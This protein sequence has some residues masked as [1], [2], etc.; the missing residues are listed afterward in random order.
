MDESIKKA[1]K[2]LGIL[3]TVGLA[4]ALSI[5]IGAYG[6]YWVDRWLDTSPWFSLIGLGMGIVAAFRN[7]YIMYKRS[8]KGP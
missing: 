4:M 2:T 6:G 5:A 3:S 8:K 7:L 1:L